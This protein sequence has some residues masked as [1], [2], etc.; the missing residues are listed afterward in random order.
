[1]NGGWE[2][3]WI[4]TSDFMQRNEDGRGRT[5]ALTQSLYRERDAAAG[6]KFM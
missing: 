4:P 3:K 1:V 6:R 2:G 5:A